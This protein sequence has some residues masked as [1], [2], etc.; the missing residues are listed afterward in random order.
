[1]SYQM[2]KNQIS[3]LVLIGMYLWFTPTYAQN[4]IEVAESFYNLQEYDKALNIFQDCFERDTTNISCGEK[5]ALSSLKLG[6]I[7]LARELFKSVEKEDSTNQLA[8]SQLASIYDQEKNIPKTIFYYNKLIELFPHNGIYYRKIA[9]Q[10]Q[11]ARILGDAFKNYKKALDLNSRDLYSIKGLAEIFMSNNQYEDCDSILSIGIEM[12][13]LNISLHLLLA[14][15]KYRQKRYKH[16]VNLLS[17][18][19]NKLDF[20]AYYNKMLGYSY[21]QIDSFELA[22]PVL[23]KTLVDPGTKENAHYYLATAYYELDSMEYAIFHYKKAIEEGISDNVDLYHRALA[24]MYNDDNDLSSAIYHYKDAYK[25]GNDPL[26]LFYLA[27]AC[28]VYY[29]DK[30][31]A[32]NYYNKYAK[33]GHDNPEYIKYA[34]ERSRHLKELKHQKVLK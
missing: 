18:I 32:I 9:Q 16:T 19:K 21:I 20:N 31:I 25:F 29:K 3:L 13:T 17:K 24:K 6:D 12:D 28:D 1:M 27:R 34:K 26:V 33:S 15:S 7:A 4:N 14:Q 23:E 5:A 8:L 10:F 30:N 2:T 22:I 11:E